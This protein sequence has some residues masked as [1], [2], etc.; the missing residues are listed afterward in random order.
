MM[1]R[2]VLKMRAALEEI[3]DDNSDT[4]HE[5]IPTKEQFDQLGEI[6]P[7]LSTFKTVSEFWSC[8]KE[9]SL[10]LCC[11]MIYNP[12]CKVSKLKNESSDGSVVDF[13][14]KL[15]ENLDKY[16]PKTGTDEDLF[17]LGNLFHPFFRGV[18]LRRFNGRL[19][20]VKSLIVENHPSLQNYLERMRREEQLQRD[21]LDEQFSEAEMLVFELSAEGKARFIFLKSIHY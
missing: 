20:Q 21:H 15:Q 16:F 5:K 2:S 10:H 8:D 6:E 7:I 13:C 9:P 3:R 14:K 17:A 1:I 4:L 12:V 11:Y 19:E 18:M